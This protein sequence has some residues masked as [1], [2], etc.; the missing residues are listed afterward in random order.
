MSMPVPGK[1]ATAISIHEKVVLPENI[2]T[3]Q[4]KQSMDKRP[5]SEP[6]SSKQTCSTW[7]KPQTL[8]FQIFAS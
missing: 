5:N 8:C 7:T 2:D 4:I 1:R 3:R 6:R